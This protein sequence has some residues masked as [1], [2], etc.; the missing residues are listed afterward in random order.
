[1]ELWKTL[2]NT[3]IERSNISAVASELG[4]SRTTI[5]LVHS[6]RYP[7]ET[8]H[9]ERRIYEVYSRVE[10]PFTGGEISIM[11]CAERACGEAPTSSPMALK[12]WM[13]CQ[14]CSRRPEMDQ[15]GK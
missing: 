12:H 14:R 13:A 9:V 15:E 4:Y 2:L 10:C 3:A 1:M 11:Q 5:S 7:G 8:R 6:G